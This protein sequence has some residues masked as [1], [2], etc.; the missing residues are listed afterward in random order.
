MTASAKGTAE[1]PGKNVN[2]KAGLNRTMLN[3]SHGRFNQYCDYKFGTVVGVDPRYTSQTCN[4][5]G[6]V[7]KANRQSQCRFKCVSC[8]HA[9]HADLNASANI[10]ASGIGAAGRREAFSLETS[11]NRQIDLAETDNG[12]Y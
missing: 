11:M 12:Y 1:N 7:D 3:A 8:G 2:A 4:V 9:D 5:C 10:L 6:H